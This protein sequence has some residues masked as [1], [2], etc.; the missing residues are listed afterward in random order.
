MAHRM[1]ILVQGQ[2]FI[3]SLNLIIWDSMPGKLHLKGSKAPTR[4]YKT[5]E[6][7]SMKKE[8]IKCK[9]LHLLQKYKKNVKDYSSACT[10]NNQNLNKNTHKED[11]EK[12]PD[13]EWLDSYKLPHFFF[14]LNTTITSQRIYFTIGLI[15]SDQIQSS[16][17]L[18]KLY[19]NFK[20]FNPPW[21]C[22]S[23]AA[24][25]WAQ[26]GNI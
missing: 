26:Q 15:S 22:P 8:I 14:G 9:G 7:E 21:S 25:S 19:L 12:T 18:D 16:V 4:F 5:I 10:L 6:Y 11:F 1:K 3:N 17:T 20:F 24:A 2:T 23:L 13:L